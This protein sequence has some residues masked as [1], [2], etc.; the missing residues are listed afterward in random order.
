MQRVDKAGEHRAACANSTS[1]AGLAEK[2][3]VVAAVF[4]LDAPRAVCLVRDGCADGM[5]VVMARCQRRVMGERC[6][7]RTMLLLKVMVTVVAS[8]VAVQP[9]S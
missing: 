6:P 4:G 1:S 5:I 3:V 8:K 9:A 2:V 7:L